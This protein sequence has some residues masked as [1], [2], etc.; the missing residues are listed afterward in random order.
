M[1]FF[2]VFCFLSDYSDY[3]DLPSDGNIT[4]CATVRCASGTECQVL[5]KNCSAPP[6]ETYPSC[7]NVTES[8]AGGCDTMR[9]GEGETCEEAMVKCAKAPCPRHAMCMPSLIED[10]LNETLSS[11][12]SVTCP[13]GETCEKTTVQC[14]VAPCPRLV[15]CVPQAPHLVFNGSLVGCE[16]VTCPQGEICE[17][18]FIDCVHPPCSPWI[19][20]VP[21]P[22]HPV[23]ND[24][25]VGCEVV[26]CPQGEICEESYVDC[27]QPPC[28]PWISC[29]P[30][31]N[32][33]E[34]T[35]QQVTCPTGQSCTS[36]TSTHLFCSSN[37][38]SSQVVTCQQVTCPTGQV[39]QMEVAG[40]DMKPHMTTQ[41][42][43]PTAVSCVPMNTNQNSTARQGCD[44]VR[45]RVNEIC[46]EQEVQCLRAPC[47][48]QVACVSIIHTNTT[49]PSDVC[50]TNQTMSDC[51]NS[52]SEAKCPGSETHLNLLQSMMCTKHCGQ[53]CACAQGFVR[54]NDGECYKPKDCPPEQMCGQNEEYKCEKCAG[55]CKTPEPNCPGPKNK[56]CKKKCI[57]AAGFVKKN[58]KCVTL[59]SCPDH[60][61]TN[62][63]CLG[64][65]DFTDCLPKCRQLCSG[66]QECDKNMSTEM[67]TPGC[68]CRG[69]YKLD[70]NGTCVH[71]R[72]CFKT[73]ECPEN[74][75]W[76]K[77]ISDDNLCNAATILKVPVRDSCFSGCICSTGFARNSNGTCVE[78]DKC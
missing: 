40:C 73:T 26:T 13:V 41:K 28:S 8:L 47:P 60:D 25:L 17:E 10:V 21:E 65:Q 39:C 53:G 27:E 33:K 23:F 2:T 32:Q 71:N 20:C 63:T 7:V 38:T 44:V 15:S 42:P 49:V 31:K 56:S 34:V 37:S 59:A 14:F 16:V 36:D 61:H 54:S 55:T 30:Q 64:T 57:C 46:E 76:S 1:P 18:S 12:A 62:I 78:Q 3:S 22:S 9:C 72:H 69:N 67:C 43:C 52:C 58:G 5:E 29:V 11:C 74:E 68:V 24:S 35:C 75:E 50:P 45:C 48:I 51:L 77:C 66:V 6:C 4:Q 70:S 19:S